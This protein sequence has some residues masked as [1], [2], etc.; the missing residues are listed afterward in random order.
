[1]FGCFAAG[2]LVAAGTL[3]PWRDRL[4]SV[5]IITHPHHRGRGHGRAVV[6]AMSRHGLQQG[7]LL[8]YQSLLANAPSLSIARSLGYQ[9]HARTL[10]IRLTPPDPGERVG[11]N[12]APE[13]G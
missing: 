5:G 2:T 6:S 9:Q 3:A 4:W 10:A 8:R 11:D 13:T 1:V 7:W 12:L